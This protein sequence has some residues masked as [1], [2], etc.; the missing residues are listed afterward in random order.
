MKTAQEHFC[1]ILSSY[2]VLVLQYHDYRVTES[3]TTPSSL[4]MPAAHIMT[5]IS[6]VFNFFLGKT[7][8]K[9]GQTAVVHYVGKLHPLCDF[10]YLYIGRAT[11]RI[12]YY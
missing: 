9:P 5:L 11:S 3:L 6:F 2:F 7:F 12:I 1:E 8:P 4:H 10:T